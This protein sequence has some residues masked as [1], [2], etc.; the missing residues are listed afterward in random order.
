MSVCVV[1]RGALALLVIRR[2]RDNT[3]EHTPIIKKI[4][5][6]HSPPARE[7]ILRRSRLQP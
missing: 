5:R 4:K 7:G 3:G 6:S 2:M 1:Y